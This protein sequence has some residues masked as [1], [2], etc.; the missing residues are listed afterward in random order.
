MSPKINWNHLI[1][2]IIGWVICLYALLW[3]LTSCS[4]E[5]HLIKSQKHLDAAK[6]KG[7]VV[8]P[9]TVWSYKYV[10][11]LIYDTLT[12]S[13]LQVMRKDSTIHTVTNTVQIGMSRQERLAMESHFKHLEKMMK[14]ENDKLQ[15]QLK[16]ATK[17]NGQNKKTERVIVKQENKP[18]MW[19]AISL[20]CI[21]MLAG[22]ITYNRFK[23]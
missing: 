1:A 14:L 13:Y 2:I 9:D 4:A 15:K 22:I 18:W 17:Q 12:N 11:E 3:M 21:V 19:I 7:A 23:K 20:I 5:K 16:A 6:R 10:P 8:T